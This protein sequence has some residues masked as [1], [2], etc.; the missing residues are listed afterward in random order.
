MAAL[1]VH[2]DVQLS[3]GCQLNHRSD[4]AIGELGSAA[5]ML[6]HRRRYLWIPSTR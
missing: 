3:K 1:E 4:T 5:M 2:Y 6:G